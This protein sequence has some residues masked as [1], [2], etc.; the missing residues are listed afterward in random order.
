MK[1]PP[2]RAESFF[3]NPPADL[4]VLLIYGPDVGA[5]KMQ[6]DLFAKNIV[7]DLHDPF[8]VAVLQSA[9]IVADSARLYDEVA[10]LS[11]GGGRRLIRVPAAEEK[12]AL[13]LSKLLDD[14]PPADSVL[15]LEAGELDRRSKLRA[16]AEGDSRAIAAVAC[17]PE[18]G[19]ARLRLI[20][21]WLRERNVKAAQEALQM[22]A[23]M[24]PPDRLALFSELEKLVLYAGDGGVIGVADVLAVLGDAASSD[25]DFT[26][27]AAGDGNGAALDAGLQRLHAESVAPIALLRAAQRHFTRLLETRTLIDQGM[28]PKEAMGKLQPRVFWKFE[29]QFVRQ[30][31]KWSAQ[32]L[33]RAL[34][35]LVDAEAQ[36]KKTGTPDN[37]LSAQLLTRIGSSAS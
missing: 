3:K 18:E 25:L 1:I 11:L 4:R 23:D 9:D 10:T 5:V 17:Y 16:L 7:A 34:A 14:W 37:A 2:A 26:V 36:C 15:L 20:H 29:G 21:G 35:A 8:R 24:T 27:M 19:E 12:I 13:T 32:K 28:N 31:Q 33:N 6:S 22:L 30:A